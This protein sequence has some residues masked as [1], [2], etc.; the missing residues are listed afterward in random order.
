MISMSG[1]R[2]I[3]SPYI[4]LVA[5]IAYLLMAYVAFHYKIR[6]LN[7]PS[8]ISI[9][10]ISIGS[11]SLHFRSFNIFKFQIALIFKG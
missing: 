6:G 3:F 11:L 10:Y 8:P 5:I 1:N 9:I 4:I 7:F 2:D